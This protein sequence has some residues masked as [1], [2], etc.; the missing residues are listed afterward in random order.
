M[1]PT[2]ALYILFGLLYFIGGFI[3]ALAF[4]PLPPEDEGP[5]VE[6]GMKLLT[7]LLW[8]VVLGFVCLSAL[9]PFYAWLKTL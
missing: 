3:C 7:A 2:T 5:Y 1:T 8:P 4:D 9:R 6:G